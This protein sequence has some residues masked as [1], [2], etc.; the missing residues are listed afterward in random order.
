MKVGDLNFMKSAEFESFSK[1]VRGA[2]AK[3]CARVNEPSTCL[4]ARALIG[5]VNITSRKLLFQSVV[6][7][8]I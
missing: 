4:R 7:F 5:L 8:L 6:R 3:E 2:T 1:M